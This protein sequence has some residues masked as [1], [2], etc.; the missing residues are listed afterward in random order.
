MTALYDDWNRMRAS[1]EPVGDDF[2]LRRPCR[3]V[4]RPAATSRS[5]E[6]CTV[7]GELPCAGPATTDRGPARSRSAT[8][9]SEP[10]CRRLEPVEPRSRRPRRF[11]LRSRG[12][13]LHRPRIGDS[14]ASG[15]VGRRRRSP[16]RSGLGLMRPACH[17]GGVRADARE[18]PDDRARR[19]ARRPAPAGLAYWA[20]HAARGVPAQARL[21]EDPGARR[22]ARRRGDAD[23]P[24]RVA[25]VR[26]PAPPRHPAPLRLPAR[27]RRRARLAGPSP[28]ARPSTRRPGAWPSTSRTTRSST[29]TSRA[30]SRPSS[31]AAAT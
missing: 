8:V 17:R 26:R 2:A 4:H 12:F 23:A 25:P 9:R 19:T 16:P 11:T 20:P 24:G 15:P 14:A 6:R 3:R 27:D 13:R 31:T 29:S 18:R 10:R 7:D 21:R 28:R 1:D 22:P 30:S 5:R